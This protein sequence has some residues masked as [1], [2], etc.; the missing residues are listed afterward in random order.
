MDRTE[1]FLGLIVFFLASIVYVIGEGD[2]T[3]MIIVIP[4][5]ITL[6]GL[7]IYLVINSFADKISN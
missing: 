5:M 1:W 6:Y 4:L 7:P 2:S 3:P